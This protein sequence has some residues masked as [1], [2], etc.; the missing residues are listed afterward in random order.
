MDVTDRRVRKLLV[1]MEQE[2]DVLREYL[3][4]NERPVV[5]FDRERLNAGPKSTSMKRCRGAY[6]QEKQKA[7]GTL[8]EPGL[9]GFNRATSYSPT[10]LRVQYHR[11]CEA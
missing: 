11:G 5:L 6:L 9:I 3:E 7:P 4:R 10:H 8:W 1:R 2:V